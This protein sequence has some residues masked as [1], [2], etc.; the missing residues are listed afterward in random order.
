[1]VPTDATSLTNV[2]P[3]KRVG[4]TLLSFH[5]R[6]YSLSVFSPQFTLSHRPSPRPVCNLFAERLH[7]LNISSDPILRTMISKFKTTLWQGAGCPIKAMASYVQ[8]CP[9]RAAATPTLTNGDYAH[10]KIRPQS[11]TPTN[12]LSA[13]LYL[14]DVP[15]VGASPG[16]RSDEN[17]SASPGCTGRTAW[18]DL[19]QARSATTNFPACL[20][21]APIAACQQLEA[22]VGIIHPRKILFQICLTA[23]KRSQVSLIR[24]EAMAVQRGPTPGLVHSAAA[25]H[26]VAFRLPSPLHKLQFTPR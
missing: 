12:R 9:I 1:L 2:G 25:K 3:V 21:D 23:W 14:G 22:S 13:H 8:P 15:G 4:D 6:G 17:E 11:S 19:P 18:P 10:P 7:S 24:H 5:Y 20:I 26:R 16:V